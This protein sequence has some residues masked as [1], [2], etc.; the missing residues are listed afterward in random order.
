MIGALRVLDRL[1]GL[2]ALLV[3]GKV[4]AGT[5]REACRGQLE[6]FQEQLL[7]VDPPFGTTEQVECPDEE[8]VVVVVVRWCPD[9]F[10]AQD[11]PPR[12]DG[13]GTHGRPEV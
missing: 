6:G 7:Y 8:V 1:Q 5:P 11:P 4:W 12:I 10:L 9:R 13:Q 3:V 2:C